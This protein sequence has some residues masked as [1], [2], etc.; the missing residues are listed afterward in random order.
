MIGRFL[1][2]RGK[3]P[4]TYCDRPLRTTCNIGLDPEGKDHIVSLTATLRNGNLV[5]WHYHASALPDIIE[6]LQAAQIRINM[7]MHPEREGLPSWNWGDK[8]G[9]RAFM[10]AYI[11]RHGVEDMARVAKERYET[12]EP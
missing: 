9:Y 10:R 11:D 2:K 3:S 7:Q 1:G 5:T 6:M 12:C 4:K 8:E